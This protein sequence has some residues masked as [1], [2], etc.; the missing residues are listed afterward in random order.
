MHTLNLKLISSTI[1]LSL[2]YV[3]LRDTKHP[4][5]GQRDNSRGEAFALHMAGP[6]SVLCTTGGPCVQPGA[7]EQRDRS[8]PR[9]LPG[10]ASLKKE[11]SIHIVYGYMKNE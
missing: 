2:V 3:I 6:G 4:C 7:N 8:N 10:V 5:T 1:N 9:I 11:I